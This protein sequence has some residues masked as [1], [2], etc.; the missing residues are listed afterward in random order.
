M[1]KGRGA[2]GENLQADFPPKC[3]AQ[4]S[5]RSHNSEIMTQRL[6]PELKPRVRH[7]TDWAIQV[8]QYQFKILNP[9]AFEQSLKDQY[10]LFTQQ[11]SLLESHTLSL[12]HA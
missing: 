5:A 9:I 2:E 8:S 7:L 1:R 4:H 11:N 12:L 6:W 10:N 3:R